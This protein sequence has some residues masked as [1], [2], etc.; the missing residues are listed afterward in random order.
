MPAR[1]HEIGDGAAAFGIAHR[2]HHAGR[3]V[4]HDVRA[5]P[6]GPDDAPV[7]L[8]ARVVV[9]ARAELA[10]DAPADAHAA[11]D[12][13]LLGAPARRDAGRREILLEPQA[14]PSLDLLEVERRDEL[15]VRLRPRERGVDSLR[16]FD[17][18]DAGRVRGA[19]RSP[20]AARS[21]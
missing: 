4:Q 5:R 1:A 9:D 14:A 6:G 10:H 16:R 21:R 12:D 8:D 13:Q 2:R 17:R 3:F 7:D 18:R 15:V 20:C 19:D 11:G